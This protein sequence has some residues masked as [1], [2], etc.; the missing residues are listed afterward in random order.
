VR[1]K[2]LSYYHEIE[3]GAIRG[4]GNEGSIFTQPDTGLPMHNQTQGHTRVI[5]AGAFRANTKSEEIFVLCA[6]NS[7]KDDLHIR[8]EAE[9]CVEILEVFNL[10]AR[11]KAKLPAA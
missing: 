1:F 4:D 7:M 9:C 11:I 6:S 5:P 8:F 3:D 2:S 10:R